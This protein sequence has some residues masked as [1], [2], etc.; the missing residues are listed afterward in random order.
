MNDELLTPAKL[1]PVPDPNASK[2]P[3]PPVWVFALLFLLAGLGGIVWFRNRLPEAP[4]P[5][6]R[7]T[8]IPSPTPDPALRLE[9][10]AL[11]DEL[12]P[13]V[14]ELRTL[15]PELW[16]ESEWQLIQE[17]QQRGN[18]HL[19]QRQY[20]EAAEAYREALDAAGRLLTEKPGVPARL[21]A[22]A[23]TA[24]AEGR[25]G[26]AV[27][28]IDA[29]LSLEPGHP[30]ALALRPRADR[31]EESF[32]S[33]HEARSA[34]S[35]EMP[36]RAWLILERTRDLDP[37]F[38][39]RRDVERAVR[40]AL[41]LDRGQTG[42]RAEQIRTLQER[43]ESFE[44]SEDWPAAAE[45][46]LR[47]REKDPEAV[48]AGRLERLQGFAEWEERLSRASVHLNSPQ[49][50]ELESDL[51]P[52]V[53]EA[54]PPGL[55]GRAEGFLQ[56]MTLQRQPVRVR[57]R[58]DAETSVHIQRVRRLDPFVDAELQLPPGNYVAIGSRIGYRDI[59]IEFTVPPGAEEVELDIRATQSIRDL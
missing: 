31:A 21:R 25:G 41:N 26:D 8:P 47:L 5:P 15:F 33:L 46:W 54:L 17:G 51:T 3:R 52:S 30:Q 45:A 50:R 23:E 58:S 57:L 36:E 13:E 27:R 2:A 29:W 37:E 11:L 22:L 32:K 10:Q 4:P 44:A 34:L 18:V 39:G 48:P 42:V 1:D 38:P 49:A 24:Y 55:R 12:I 9:A 6:V 19:A 7:P 43:A 20:G 16:A 35:E 28:L 59:R 40:S 14:R 53:L 56:T